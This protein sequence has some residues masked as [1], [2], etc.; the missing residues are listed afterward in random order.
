MLLCLCGVV[1]VRCS[2][3]QV[4]LTDPGSS[5]LPFSL[6]YLDLLFSSHSSN[7]L[8]FSL[9]STSHHGFS[10]GRNPTADL[11][12]CKT[13]PKKACDSLANL[14]F[15]LGDISDVSLRCLALVNNVF[16]YAALPRIY[17]S[18]V[19]KFYDYD[20]LGRAVNEITTSLIGSIIKRI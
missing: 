10:T 2:P 9:F 1:V 16:Y 19:I 3:W 20:T 15:Q 8:S 13:Q 11:Y 5:L 17:E 7:F 6:S 14:L 18:V 12:I 4:R